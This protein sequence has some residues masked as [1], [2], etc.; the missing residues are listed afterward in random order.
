MIF[1]FIFSIFIGF[2]LSI[3]SSAGRYYQLQESSR[4]YQKFFRELLE[5]IGTVLVH[6]SFIFISTIILD[7]TQYCFPTTADVLFQHNFPHHVGYRPVDATD[8]FLSIVYSV[9]CCMGFP[10]VIAV[11]LVVYK[12]FVSRPIVSFSTSRPFLMAV[13]GFLELFIILNGVEVFNF[14]QRDPYVGHLLIY[15]SYSLAYFALLNGM[16]SPRYLILA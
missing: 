10:F 12:T 13:F 16:V 3:L 11:I 2:L 6:L 8:A 14:Y 15:F 5:R 1:R 9:F 4:F 7:W